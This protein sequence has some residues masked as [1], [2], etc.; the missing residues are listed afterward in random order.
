VAR[1]FNNILKSC[2]KNGHLCLVPNFS[3]KDFS[4]SPL[5]TIFAE[6]VLYMTLNVF[7]NVPSIQL[8]ESFILCMD[9]RLCHTLLLHLLRP[10]Y[11]FDVSIFTVVYD[12]D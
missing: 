3:G 9:F 5:S 12:V 10:S 7:R 11:V 1:T 6:G 8:G 2:G 4:F